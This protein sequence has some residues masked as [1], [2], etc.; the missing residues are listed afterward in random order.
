[1]AWTKPD[2]SARAPGILALIDW[3]NHIVHWLVYEIV[4]R[5]ELKER[6][7]VLEKIVSVGA[8]LDKLNNLIGTRE[9]FSAINSSSVIRLQ[10]TFDG[11]SNRSRSI[12]ADLNGLNS[13]ELNHK[14]YRTRLQH[15]RP[16]ALPFPGICQNDLVFIEE[17]SVK[18]KLDGDLI[19]VPKFV[20]ISEMIFGFTVCVCVSVFLHYGLTLNFV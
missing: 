18:N 4:S 2:A 15:V 13:M 11:V 7:A 9:I 8:H 3:F 19:N 17:C 20:K 16:P 1:M 12:I 6:I 10:A 5:K 14:Q